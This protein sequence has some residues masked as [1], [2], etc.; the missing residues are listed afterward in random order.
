MKP[1]AAGPPRKSLASTRAAPTSSHAQAEAAYAALACRFEDQ[2]RVSLPADK[3][4]KFG[5]NALKVDGKIFAMLVKGA[6]AVKLSP[7][8]VESATTAGRGEPL[9]MGRRVMKEWLLVREPSQRW[10]AMAEL[11]R[12]FV[13][14]ERG[15][16][17]SRSPAAPPE[18]A[19]GRRPRPTRRN[20]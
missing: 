15:E 11:A 3:R 2:P 6:L 16:S 20:R 1:R 5:S 9:S 13:A 4:G 18:E 10:Y 14:G 12:A 7:A 8:A 17:R 19:S